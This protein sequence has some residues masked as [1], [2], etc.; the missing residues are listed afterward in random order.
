MRTVPSRLLV[1]AI[2]VRRG[3][4]RSG[5][6]R[7]RGVSGASTVTHHHLQE[8][9][10]HL[11]RDLNTVLLHI[12]EAS[13]EDMRSGEKLCTLPSGN[14]TFPGTRSYTAA[15]CKQLLRNEGQPLSWG[16]K[17][18]VWAGSPEHELS[19]KAGAAAGHSWGASVPTPTAH[20][21]W[22]T[23]FPLWFTSPGG[24]VT[25]QGHCRLCL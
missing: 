2:S 25:Q 10:N 5:R 8:V 11:G 16:R 1:L 4:P 7:V 18:P 12:I 15:L 22:A 19:G 14:A 13:Q 17:Q 6:P 3:F 9:I 24:S 20:R 21:L 23:P